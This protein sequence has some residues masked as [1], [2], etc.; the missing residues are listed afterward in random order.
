MLQVRSVEARKGLVPQCPHNWWST[1]VTKVH[2]YWSTS[3][4]SWMIQYLLVYQ[5][6]YDLL[7][8]YFPFYTIFFFKEWL[9]YFSN[10]FRM[11]WILNQTFI[12]I[13]EHRLHNRY[14]Y[15]SL[16][17]G[18]NIYINYFPLWGLSDIHK[19][20]SVFVQFLFKKYW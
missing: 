2:N 13:I 8:Q 18:I 11:Q 16:F 1:E 14:N 4:L 10:L 5:L 17:Y 12:F 6:N 20:Y 3:L 15:N 7:M 9:N 19:W